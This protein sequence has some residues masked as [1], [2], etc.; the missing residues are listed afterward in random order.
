MLLVYKNLKIKL[1]DNI[2]IFIFFL[3]IP[4]TYALTIN[5]GFPLKIS[6][7][8]LFIIFIL[9]IYKSRFKVYPL[10]QRVFVL[11]SVFILFT[12]GSVTV[13]LFWEYPYELNTFDSRFG[14][15]VDSFLK[16]GYV[17]L[18]YFS[19][20]VTS[21]SFSINPNKYIKVFLY[22]AFIASLYSWYLFLMSLLELPYILLPGMDENP[23]IVNLSFGNVIRCGTFKEGNYMGLFLLI[24]SFMAFYIGRAK[25]GWF[26]LFTIISTMA[27]MSIICGAIFLFL[28]YF[29]SFFNKRNIHKL[30][31]SAVG[32]MVIFTLLL[33]S[34]DF[35]FLITSKLFGNTEKI[36]NNAEYSKADRLNS[37]KIALKIGLNNPVLGVG[38]SN[39]ALHQKEFN[40]DARFFYKNFKGIPNNIYLEI[41]AEIGLIGLLLFLFFLFQLYNL[42]YYDKSKV[43]RFGFL[44][45]LLYFFAFPTFTMIFIWVFWGLILSLPIN[46]ARSNY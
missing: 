31:M 38:L 27:S 3:F 46:H 5:L 32:V 22:G 21:N 37:M 26:F 42:T 23:Q 40:E 18:A 8:S 44:S 15:K 9:L 25:A 45:T 34:K 43:L 24:S 6:E 12:F 1:F 41:F 14:Y 19:L 10:R 11:I 20:I 30:V 16:Y 7:V 4:F 39:Y 13:N 29:H 33:Q 2:L 35:H 28:Y 36:S 17:L